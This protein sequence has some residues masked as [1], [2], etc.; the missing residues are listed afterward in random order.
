MAQGPSIMACI[1]VD[2]A[3][4]LFAP[5]TSTES[6]FEALLYPTCRHSVRNSNTTP[7]CK[8]ITIVDHNGWKCIL[9]SLKGTLKSNL[10]LLNGY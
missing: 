7:P 6:F 2:R 3:W 4:S 10:N 5:P 9:V 1:S 8:C